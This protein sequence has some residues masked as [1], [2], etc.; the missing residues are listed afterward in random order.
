MPTDPD[1]ITLLSSSSTPITPVVLSD[2]PASPLDDKF[3]QSLTDN[4][5]QFTDNPLVPQ[6][7][8]R[9]N[10]LLPSLSDSKAHPNNIQSEESQSTT[11]SPR[12]HSSNPTALRASTQ[13]AQASFL[14]SNEFKHHQQVSTQKRRESYLQRRK[15][16]RRPKFNPYINYKLSNAFFSWEIVI[17]DCKRQEYTIQNT[18]LSLEILVVPLTAIEVQPVD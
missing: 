8:S 18:A 15:S 11:S 14:R 5:I 2:P 16:I 9:A 3:L 13:D 12:Q 6:H 7:E 4:W 1:I 17:R 10:I